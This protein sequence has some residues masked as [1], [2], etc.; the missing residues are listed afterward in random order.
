MSEQTA[1]RWE[2]DADN[3]VVLTM[4]DPNQSANTMNELYGK[5]MAAVVERLEKEKDE[6]A[7][8]IITSAKK[9]FFAGG[10]LRDLLKARKE[11]GPQFLAGVTELKRQLRIME[12]LGKPVVA[13]MNGTALGGG[14]EIALACHHRVA[15]NDKSAQ[16]GL[17]EVSLGLLPGGGGV[18]RIVRMLGI[19]DG[20]MKVLMQGQRMKADKAQK[21]G[22]IDELVADRD[23]M[24]AKAREWIKANP[25]AMQP[26]DQKGYKIPGGDPKNP[27]FAVNLPAFPANLKKQ[28]KGANYP[29][30][31]AI[32]SA[33]IEGAAVDFDNAS[34]IEG[35]Y[36]VSLVTSQVA[37]NMITAFFFNLQAINGGASRPDGIEKFRAEKVGV[38]GAGMMGAGVAYVTARSGS[39]VVLKDISA[40]NAE[41][42]KDYSRKLLD[43]EISKG[44]M[45]EEKKEEIL[46]RITAT[47]DAKD[48][49]G[50]DFVIEAVFE[51]TEL[52]HKVFQEIEDVVNPDAVLGSNTSSLPI[53]GLAKGV[54]KK[55]NFIGI[56]FFSP[57]DKMPLVEIICGKDTCPEALA[58]T[59]DYCLQ[60][61]K[62][63]IV[64]ND[65]RGFFTTRVIGTFANEGIAMLGEGVNAQSIEQAAMQ[66]GYP[67]GTLNL[68]DEINMETALKIGKAARDDAKREGAEL[69]PE[70]PAEVVMKKM[71]EELDRPGKL[72]GKGFYEYPE[73]G[74]K[75]LWPGLADA[76]GGSKDMPFE[77]IKERMMF[78]ESLEAVKCFDEGVMDSVADANIGSIFGIG[79]PAWTGGVMQYINQYEGGLRG[80]V[81]RA[82][83]LAKL[84]GERFNPPASLV[85]KAEKGEIYK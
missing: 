6:I 7:G 44:K 53:T 16:F 41:K 77:D 32:M 18:T 31:L 4:D 50:V 39:Q 73:N 83:E 10:D 49:E 45:T 8:V 79:F 35:R 5:S 78:I 84:Y 58:K 51:N 9:T 67:V 66:A 71:V 54:K 56:H 59:Y 21:I 34:L 62:T 52:K 80:F 43:K 26:W 37:K 69:P 75:H 68:I 81:A 64:V 47:A 3:I 72:Q 65:A 55:D 17:P 19:Q 24:M 25:K 1:I 29:A 46:G 57:V 14:L 28:V 23:A 74:K 20:L 36:F 30:P 33:A 60:I 48:L 15:I 27:K 12:T 70:H 13:A 42:G 63:P 2:K 40:E 61:K 76:F 38:L 11:D 82:Q 22:L 85:E